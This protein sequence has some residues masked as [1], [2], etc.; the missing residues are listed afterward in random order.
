MI[1][2]TK[3][4]FSGYKRGQRVFRILSDAVKLRAADDGIR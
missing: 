2:L 1:W 4:E 3:A